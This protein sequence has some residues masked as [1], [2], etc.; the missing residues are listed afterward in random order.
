MPI[1]HPLVDVLEL[2]VDH[3]LFGAVPVRRWSNALRARNRTTGSNQ[4][5]SPRG[6]SDGSVGPGE[7]AHPEGLP[8]TPCRRSSPS[9]SF[10]AARERRRANAVVPL[11][12]S[13]ASTSIFCSPSYKEPTVDALAP[14]AE[15]GR[16]WLRK[17]TGSCLPSFDPWMSE[18][19]NPAPVMGCHSGLNT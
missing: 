13:I 14:E 9:C 3:W 8:P 12:N 16:G 11:E 2:P 4:T 10:S 1:E 19:G 17:A 6:C 18:W 5:C 7:R 15:E